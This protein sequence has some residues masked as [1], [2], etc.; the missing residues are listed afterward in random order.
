MDDDPVREFLE[1]RVSDADEEI[2]AIFL[3]AWWP[4]SMRWSPEPPERLP[5]D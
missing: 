2:A 3:N 5:G 4:G 1:A